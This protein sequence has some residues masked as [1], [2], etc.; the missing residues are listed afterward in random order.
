MKSLITFCLAVITFIPLS[1]A[2]DSSVGPDLK[3]TARTYNI[4]SPYITSFRTDGPIIG[5]GIALTAFGTYLISKKKDLTMEQ[6]ARKTKD[7]VPFFD[8]SSAG[9]YSEKA[10]E[11][12]YIPFKISFALPVAMMLANKNERQ[13]PVQ[14]LALY[15]ETMGITGALFTIAAGSIQRSRPFVYGTLAPL[16]KRLEKN[17][18]RAFYA[19]HT[20]ATA[21]ATFFAAKVF[22][23]FNPNSKLK[24]YVWVVAASVPALVGY[25]RY[26]AGMHF[27]SDNL[28]GYVMGAG[29]GILVPELHKNSKLK[30]LSFTPEAGLHYKGVALTYNF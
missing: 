26:K 14:V 2:Q 4:E 21:S 7:R 20:A 27:L 11:D 15:V 13:K 16:D 10:D 17:S 1:H 28:L 9:F 19:G 5:G 6:L 23:D 29:A 22:Q 3:Q 18:Q 12:S 30:N 24:P 25:L 8:R